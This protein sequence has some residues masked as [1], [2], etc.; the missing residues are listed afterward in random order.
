MDRDRNG[1]NKRTDEFEQIAVQTRRVTKVTKG[2]K[3]FTFSALVV[4]GNRKGKVGVGI[5]KA[6]DARTA[7]D[8]GA[9][10]AKKH[11]I[12]VNLK[13]STIPHEVNQKLGASRI[14]LKPAAPG[15]GLI[16]GGSIRPVLELAGVKDIL[17]KMMGTNNKIS[18]VYCMID[19]LSSLKNS[20]V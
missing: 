4:V 20:K 12:I 17:S 16:A 8:K 9:R 14:M 19:A 1:Q 6:A 13:G 3:K 15:T 18:N 10:Y 11:L 7:I 2:A 5:G